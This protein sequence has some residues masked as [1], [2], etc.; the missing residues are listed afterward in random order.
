MATLTSINFI[1]SVAAILMLQNGREIESL[2]GARLRQ[3]QS[4]YDHKLK[5]PVPVNQTAAPSSLDDNKIRPARMAFSDELNRSSDI[6]EKPLNATEATQIWDNLQSRGCCG[7]Q[8]YTTEWK[9]RIPKSC[10]AKPVEAANGEQQCKEVDSD[11]QKSCLAIISSL[12]LYLLIVLAL[13]ALVNLYLAT[14]TGISTYRT[15][16]YNEASQSAYT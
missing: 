2:I 13:V 6:G 10:C 14:V 9:D 7:Y 16:N 12:D 3:A 1:L 15:L 8:N 11:H 5:F 4:L